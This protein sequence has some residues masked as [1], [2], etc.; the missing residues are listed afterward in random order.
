MRSAL[1]SAYYKH[2]HPRNKDSIATVAAIDATFGSFLQLP[3]Q[4]LTVDFVRWLICFPRFIW[5][6]KI[7][8][9]LEVEQVTNDV[10]ANT[11]SHNLLGMADISCPRSHILI[12]PLLSLD[13][14]VNN[15]SDLK[16]LSIGPR[17]EGE[18]FNLMGYGF[19]SENITGVDLISYSPYIKIGNMHQL[20][21]EDNSFDVIVCGWCISHSDEPKK[22]AEEIMRVSKPGAIVSLGVAY[23]P[24]H[25]RVEDLAKTGYTVGP[26][27]DLRITSL[28][29]MENLFQ[30]KIKHVF[31]NHDAYDADTHSSIITIFQL[32]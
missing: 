19:K 21:F 31:F 24:D 27:A 3:R 25:L 4:L 29:K 22:A 6:S 17:T 23:A 2:I 14:I 20:P 5:F 15:I 10:S 7:M 9:K 8:R 32:S 28:E 16:V 18:I 30:D 1:K 12:R 11:I 13:P 26:T